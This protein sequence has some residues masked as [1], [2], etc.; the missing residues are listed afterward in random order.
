[1]SEQLQLP[2]LS[3]KERDLRWKKARHEMSQRSLDCLIVS[4]DD[5]GRADSGIAHSRFLTCIGG[6]GEQAY[7]IFPIEGEP[8]CLTMA[9]GAW[10]WGKV[11]DWVSDIRPGFPKSTWAEAIA[12]RIKEMKHDKRK[13]GIVG[14]QGEFWTDGTIKYATFEKLK[15]LLPEATFSEATD[16][17]ET[18]QYTKSE[19]V[20]EFHKKAALLGDYAVEA[21]KKSALPGVKEY[22]VYARMIDA[23][24]S[25]GGEY[26]PL[27][28]WEAAKEPHHPARLPTFRKLE[29]G[30]LIVNEISA[31]YGGYWAHP[32]QPLS[33]ASPPPSEYQKMFEACL[34]SMKSGLKLLTPGRKIK[35]V[36]ESFLAPIKS[37]GYSS[38]IAPYQGLGLNQT[39]P[40]GQVVLEGMVI[41]VQPWVSNSEGT[42]G[43]NIGETYSISSSGPVR[44]GKR[45]EIEFMVS[46]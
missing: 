27:I 28:I 13:I 11:Q 25:N 12:A 10:W 46:S 44:L 36:N 15:R 24:I 37:A 3:L 29:K 18:A 5:S 42:R 8:T 20:I 1:M 32:H 33:V 14:L 31:K 9:T 30:D 41:G 4:G 43:L 19:E 6:N 34:D 39:E 23:I 17:L 38:T 16:I 45:E 2:R 22:E 7:T 35:E 40:L 26:P 21:M